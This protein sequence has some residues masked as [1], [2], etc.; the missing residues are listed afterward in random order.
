AEHL[1]V[2]A[3]VEQIARHTVLLAQE[4]RAA[5]E[6]PGLV[7]TVA[8]SEVDVRVLPVDPRDLAGELDLVR[9]VER[10]RMVCGAEGWEKQCANDRNRE[11]ARH[12][13]SSRRR[14]AR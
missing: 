9:G 10:H 2:V 7:R 12:R 5:L 6:R 3:D 13:A 14:W 11:R 4:D 8:E 1:H